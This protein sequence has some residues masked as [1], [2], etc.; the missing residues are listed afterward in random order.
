MHKKRVIARIIGMTVM[1]L[2]LSTTPN[3][4]VVHA[5][6]ETGGTETVSGGDSGGTE[7]NYGVMT[8][9]DYTELS[10]E[11]G[12]AFLYDDGTLEVQS[13]NEITV[14]SDTKVSDY[15]W[16]AEK[17]NIKAVKFKDDIL[18]IGFNAFTDYSGIT[19]NLELPSGLIEIYD[20][21]FSGCSGLTGELVFP[22]TITKIGIGAFKK[23]SG[24]TGDLVIPDSVIEMGDHTL[25][26]GEVFAGCTGFTSVSIG[27]GL[28]FICYGAF[29]GCKGLKGDLVIPDNIKEIG[30]Y[31]F[32]NCTGYETIKLGANTEGIY[33]SA[34]SGCTGLKGNI[35]I[36]AS[37]TKGEGNVFYKCTGLTSV[38]FENGLTKILEGMF[39]EC[40]GLSGTLTLP[41]TITKIEKEAFRGCTGLSG[42]L[43]IPDSVTSIATGAF[44][45]CTGFN[46]KLTI[47]NGITKIENNV[48][49]GCNNIKEV[50][51]SDNV[52]NIGNYAFYKCTSLASPLNLSNG[53][54]EIGIEAFNGCT[55]LTEVTLPETMTYIGRNAFQNCTC[56]EKI[57]LNSLSLSTS[58]SYTF[59]GAGNTSTG[60][61][62]VMS[63]GV[64]KIPQKLFAGMKAKITEITIPDT[65][66]T[67]ETNIFKGANTLEDIVV[68]NSTNAV[69]LAYDWNEDLIA[70][71]NEG[72]NDDNEEIP[73]E[74]PE[75][76][77]VVIDNTEG[78]TVS[79]T[80]A[81][82][83]TMDVTISLNGL[84]FMINEEREFIAQETEIINNC[85]YPIVVY[86]LNIEKTANEPDIVA[87]NKYT[88]YEWNNLSRR[89]TESNL[90]LKVNDT[91]L[92]TI[93][94]N[95]AL[96]K[97]KAIYFGDIKSAYVAP[98]KLVLVPSAQ[99]GKN[100]S[101]EDITY[102]YSMVFEFRI[103]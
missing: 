26:G 90:A 79:G 69:A 38:T 56:L 10:N 77:E 18:A 52:T 68:L 94:N 54:L 45:E 82:I 29:N 88:D 70:F 62:L 16:Y 13:F 12:K 97:T 50:S 86:A 23:C 49:N 6:E 101:N 75:G 34:F 67:M 39:R 46:N 36:P 84:S 44:Q 65:V 72:G 87:E 35:T 28:E 4:L 91:E 96:D 83:S 73:D 93:F 63:D 21:A 61:K 99:Y 30:R 95:S 98:Q 102:N 41:N 59:N 48:F 92:Y 9:S 57:N 78:L 64:T 81:P 42:D 19:S 43:V 27:S 3:M 14:N 32:E 24:L 74:I 22:D 1:S 31:A 80:I 37:L 53:L 40:T 20:N 25:N 8:M 66:T 33:K 60:I 2:V 5:A 51:M 85:A 47:G 7:E 100:F 71:G 55:S 11:Y 89:E 15:P 76:G 58:G 103:P 17:D